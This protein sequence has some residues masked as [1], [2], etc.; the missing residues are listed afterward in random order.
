MTMAR[1]TTTAR[2]KEY[3]YTLCDKE[4]KTENHTQR[5]SIGRWL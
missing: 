3:T 2:F 4:G 5:G 1:S